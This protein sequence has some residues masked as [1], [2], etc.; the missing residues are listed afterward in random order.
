MDGGVGGRNVQRK[1][2]GVPVVGFGGDSVAKVGEEGGE[3]PVVVCN[4]NREGIWK[5]VGRDR[6][7]RAAAQGHDEAL[8]AEED[9]TMTGPCVGN[10][11]EGLK[12]GR[13]KREKGNVVGKKENKEEVAGLEEGG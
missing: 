1:G 4:G 6:G 12:V 13:G 7:G 2:G 11:Q 8:G 5:V 9:L 10:G 3:V